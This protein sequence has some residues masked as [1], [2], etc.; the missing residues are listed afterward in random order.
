[1]S[2]IDWNGYDGSPAAAQLYRKLAV[3]EILPVRYLTRLALISF[4]LDNISILLRTLS[5]GI[6]YTANYPITIATFVD[7]EGSYR[8]VPY[9]PLD[10]YTSVPLMFPELAEVFKTRRHNHSEC[11]WSLLK[12]LEKKMSEMVYL[13]VD[14]QGTFN[15]DGNSLKHVLGVVTY[16]QTSPTDVSQEKSMT[17]CQLSENSPS[18]ELGEIEGRNENLTKSELS[19]PWNNILQQLQSME[20]RSICRRN[21]ETLPMANENDKKSEISSTTR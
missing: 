1:M 21:L 13:A 14:E 16:R 17:V 20:K 15:S 6:N 10:A 11:L 2:Y 8:A 3:G 12:A 9:V 19:A 5:S 7:R 4:T 18:D